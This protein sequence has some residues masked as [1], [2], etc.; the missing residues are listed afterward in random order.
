MDFSES[1]AD[2]FGRVDGL[3]VEIH[4]VLSASSGINPSERTLFRSIFPNFHP[5]FQ[6]KARLSVLP[7]GS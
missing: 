4:V 5:Y 1:F 2:F 7:F 3:S 6:L